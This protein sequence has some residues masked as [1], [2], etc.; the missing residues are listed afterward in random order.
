MEVPDL[1]S[2]TVWNLDDHISVVDQIKI[3]VIWQLG[4]NVEISL[5]IKT[6]LLVELSLSWLLLILVNI[7]D[8]PLLVSLSILVFNNNVSVLIV[9]ST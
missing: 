5:N 8:L 1:G 7:D 9:K 3:S 4:N 2:S 6:E